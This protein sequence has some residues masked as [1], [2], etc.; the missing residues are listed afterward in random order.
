MVFLYGPIIMQ[1]AAVGQVLSLVLDLFQVTG[2]P[3]ALK[4]NTA[5][6]F[7][8]PLI[9]V[10]SALHNVLDKDAFFLIWLCTPQLQICNQSVHVKVQILS[11]Y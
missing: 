8:V 7:L 3:E 5:S 4:N 1:W 2:T 11:S 6:P 9:N 10:Y